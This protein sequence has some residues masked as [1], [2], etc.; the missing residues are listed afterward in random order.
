MFKV[1]SNLVSF[2]CKSRSQDL[3]KSAIEIEYGLSEGKKA[4]LSPSLGRK[5]SLVSNIHLGTKDI[6]WPWLMAATRAYAPYIVLPFAALVG[7]IGYTI[8][9]T[10]SDKYTPWSESVS[11]RREERLLREQVSEDQREVGKASLNNPEFVPKNIFQ[12][13]VTPTLKDSQAA[14]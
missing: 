3:C 14:Q 9:S 10:V 5:F 2:L 11:Q 8:E 7:A 4:L 6:M 12:K 13:N 1:S